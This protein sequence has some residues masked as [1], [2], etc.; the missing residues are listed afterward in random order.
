MKPKGGFLMKK[1]WFVLLTVVMLLVSAF[2]VQAQ[3]KPTILTGV[4]TTVNDTS[5]T[6]ETISG[7]PF[8]I[9]TADYTRFLV[10]NDDGVADKVSFDYL[11]ADQY[12]SV[13]LVDGIAVRVTVDALLIHWEPE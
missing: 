8:D 7:E 4:I 13:E 11:A 5:F 12:V 6:L 10:R 1:S 3:G 9:Q 2:S